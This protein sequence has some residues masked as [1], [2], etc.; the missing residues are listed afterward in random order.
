MSICLDGGE[1]AAQSD[2]WEET[3]NSTASSIG[4]SFSD[5]DQPA[6]LS[7]MELLQSPNIS[8]ENSPSKKRKRDDESA[9]CS[10]RYSRCLKY[11]PVLI[12]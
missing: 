3:S 8:Q 11:L 12:I 4:G 1:D 2:T 6:G 7:S 5:E 10:N 9:D